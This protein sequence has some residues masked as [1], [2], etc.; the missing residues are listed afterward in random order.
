MILL[1]HAIVPQAPA[2]NLSLARR[3]SG[4][5]RRERA[6]KEPAD[7]RESGGPRLARVTRM[8]SRLALVAF[9]GIAAG[10]CAEYVRP[11]GPA[12]ESV[13]GVAP[14]PA[15]P[16]MEE[17]VDTC[18]HGTLSQCAASCQAAAG[19][20][21]E[22][23]GKRICKE[24][25][26]DDCQGSCD[27]GNPA[28]CDALADMYDRGWR[29]EESHAKAVELYDK[30]CK[31]G[32]RRSCGLAGE[33]LRNRLDDEGASTTRDS[34]LTATVVQYFDAACDRSAPEAGDW[35]GWDMPAGGAG[36]PCAE[37]LRMAPARILPALEA[38]CAQ[39][40]RGDDAERA[41]GL[42]VESH[43][44]S[45]AARAAALKT[46]CD[47]DPQGDACARLKVLAASP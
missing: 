44:S 25:S 22:E 38:R 42:V 17:A 23:L 2:D 45:G 29:V 10:A 47:H 6:S 18:R 21:C 8:V 3:A 30:Q 40:G 13:P 37:L 39:A 9:A 19:S 12:A 14:S 35:T 41:C 28:A 24:G 27:A 4:A 1:R 15:P 43:A 16:Q 26:V 33:V 32:R 7:A 46:V 5:L 11:T 36:N 34:E 20:S 31:K